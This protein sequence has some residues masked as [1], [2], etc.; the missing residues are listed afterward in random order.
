VRERL[1]L[2]EARDVCDGGARAGADDD[3]L[4]GEGADT[5]VV[6]RDFDGLWTDEAS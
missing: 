5:A 1:A 6:E 2:G 3:M 4:A